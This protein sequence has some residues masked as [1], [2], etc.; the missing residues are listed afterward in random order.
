M[1]I[2]RTLLLHLFDQNESFVDRVLL[3]F[4][5][6]VPLQIA[7]L[8]VALAQQD[9]ETASISAHNIKSQSSYLGLTDIVRLCQSIEDEPGVSETPVRLV[10]LE[11][12]IA[13]VLT[14]LS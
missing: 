8:R 14:E 12:L 3:I 13:L 2:N 4:K 7:E 11:G 6:Q 9:F 5:E 10:E 1:M